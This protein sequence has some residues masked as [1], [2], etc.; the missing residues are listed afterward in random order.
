MKEKVIIIII[1]TTLTLIVIL[2][3]RLNQDYVKTGKLYISEIMAKNTYTLKDDYN[4]YS[5]YIELY[6]GYKYKI[7]LEGYYLSDNI[8]DTKKYKL[9][10]IEIQPKEYL[11]IFAS[12]KNKCNLETQICHTNF[13]LAST[14]ETL[15]LSDKEGNIINKFTYPSLDNDISYGYKNNKYI[16]FAEATP[17]KE[18]TLEELKYDNNKYDIIINEYMTHNTANKYTSNGY[19][20]D[21][22]ELYNNEDKVSATNLYLS[23]DINNL[24]KYRLP[25]ITIDKDSY[26]VIYLTGKNNTIENEICASFKLGDDDEYLIL[27]NGDE[28]I[29]KVEVVKLQDNISY[30]RINDS[31]EYFTS[32]TPGRINDTISFKTL[33]GTDGDN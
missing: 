31:W 11:I 16:T 28:I 23:N 33:G 22:V 1:L 29:D 21:F 15:T 5:D 12:G 9:P 20:Y 25:S 19:Y 26:I 17:R 3:P 13:K 8:F 27:S 18:N 32:P 6:N 7:N 24:K 30:G 10:K 14:G 4:E 2:S